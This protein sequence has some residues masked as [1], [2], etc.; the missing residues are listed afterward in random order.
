MK[1][2]NSDREIVDL[3]KLTDY[4]LSHE[5][6]RGKYKARVFQSSLGLT[7]AHAGELRE[8]L[9]QKVGIQEFSVTG[10]DRY[11]TRYMVDFRY[12]RGRKEAMLRSTWI[13][14]TD[15][16]SPRLTSCFVL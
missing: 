11:G 13:I 7:A 3:R 8:V 12:R 2:P 10:T 14:K 5:H 15:E 16:D 1:V 4:C 6:P 9:L